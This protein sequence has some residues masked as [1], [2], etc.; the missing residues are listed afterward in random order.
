MGRAGE[1]VNAEASSRILVV[2]TTLATTVD[3][4]WEGV[5]TWGSNSRNHTPNNCY[6]LAHRSFSG[7][8]S[9][10]RRCWGQR[11]AGRPRYLARSVVAGRQP[12]TARFVTRPREQPG[13]AA[14]TLKDYKRA[15]RLK[16]DLSVDEIALAA[17]S[18]VCGAALE[19]LS[20]VTPGREVS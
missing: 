12:T 3:T 8:R 11:A 17:I 9:A 7:S 6:S 13:V 4:E 18:Y 15:L 19:P 5:S 16:Y 20:E 1:Q 2:S 10:R 14:V